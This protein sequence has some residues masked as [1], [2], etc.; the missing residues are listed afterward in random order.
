MKKRLTIKITQMAV[1][2]MIA[3]SVFSVVVP[4]VFANPGT[5][6]EMI[7][8]Q[9]HPAGSGPDGILGSTDDLAWTGTTTSGI[10]AA[11]FNF[12]DTIVIHGTTFYIGYQ[13]VDTNAD[14]VPDAP[15]IVVIDTDKNLANGV[16]VEQIID[17]DA[18]L[19]LL[20]PVP[21]TFTFVDVDGSTTYTAGDQVYASLGGAVAAL[22]IR[23]TPVG[24]Y[25]AGSQVVAGD[26]DI[27]T[28]YFGVIPPIVGFVDADV[29]GTYNAGD[30]VY[31]AQAGAVAANDIRLTPIGT[32]QAGRQVTAG[33]TDVGNAYSGF[34]PFA[35]LGAW[36]ADGSGTY[37]AGDPVYFAQGGAV[38][39]NDLRMSID[40]GV[41]GSQVGA[42]L[43]GLARI[44]DLNG[45]NGIGSGEVFAL[46]LIDDAA[47]A[48]FAINNDDDY[49]T[50]IELLQTDDPYDVTLQT[51]LY[52]AGTPAAQLIDGSGNE[53]T[54]DVYNVVWSGGIGTVTFFNKEA[55]YRGTWTLDIWDDSVGGITLVLEGVE[56]T[57]QVGIPVLPAESANIQLTLSP[58]PV[59]VE[60]TTTVT[61]R[62]TRDGVP[63]QA[64]VEA[65][66][67]DGAGNQVNSFTGQADS[68]GEVTFQI[69]YWRLR[70]L[71]VYAYYDHFD[72][73]ND[74]LDPTN[75]GH[76]M[77][78]TSIREL[79]GTYGDITI[80]DP[81][82][83]FDANGDTVNID[84]EY[85]FFGISST[86]LTEEDLAVTAD[87]TD[88]NLWMEQLFPNVVLTINNGDN[89]NDVD[90]PVIG[91]ANFPLVGGCGVYVDYSGSGIDH[92]VWAQDTLGNKYIIQVPT[93]GVTYTVW[94]WN[95]VGSIGVYD[96]L[97][98]IIFVGLANLN[99]PLP[100]DL[101]LDGD[102]DAVRFA[103]D[104]NSNGI[105]DNG[106]ILTVWDATSPLPVGHTTMTVYNGGVVAGFTGIEVS[107]NALSQA[108]IPV[109][110]LTT[111]DVTITTNLD[112]YLANTP[113][114]WT[115]DVAAGQPDNL[116]DYEGSI[117]IPVNA[118]AS[119][120]TLADVRIT[121][122]DFG[123]TV[124]QL[125]VYPSGDTSWFPV[126][127]DV[128][129]QPEGIDYTA[130][131][132]YDFNFYVKDTNGR[133][134]AFANGLNVWPLVTL[135]LTG[136]GIDIEVQWNDLDADS[137]YDPGEVTIISTDGLMDSDGSG[138]PPYTFGTGTA[139]PTIIGG[140][141]FDVYIDTDGPDNTANTIDDHQ[142]YMRLRPN[143]GGELNIR[144]E[145]SALQGDVN[146]PVG[147]LVIADVNGTEPGN[148]FYK[149]TTYDVN[150]RVLNEMGVVINNG[151]V[152]AW[153]D[154]DNNGDIYP[155]PNQG[156]PIPPVT[157][158]IFGDGIDND[159]DGQIDEFMEDEDG[160]GV[161]DVEAIDWFDARVLNTNN[162]SYS[163]QVTPQIVA[164]DRIPA[165]VG[166]GLH[167][168][169]VP[170]MITAY[171][172]QDVD[173]DGQLEQVEVVKA[174]EIIIPVNGQK[175][176]DITVVPPA[177]TAGVTEDELL[178]I[179]L[180]GNPVDITSGLIPPTALPTMLVQLDGTTFFN[181][182][183][184]LDTS[185]AVNGNVVDTG[186][187]FTELQ[188]GNHTY[189]V[190]TRD[191]EHWNEVIVPA[192]RPTVTYSIENS[193]LPGVSLHTMTGQM[194]R[195][196]TVELTAWDANG[197]MILGNAISNL[198]LPT[199]VDTRVTPFF[200]YLETGLMAVDDN[201][202]GVIDYTDLNG[203]G[204]PDAG[205]D[206]QWARG[207]IGAD[208]LYDL[209][210]YGTTGVDTDADG[211]WDI[212]VPDLDYP[213]FGPHT[214]TPGDSLNPDIGNGLSKF[215]IGPQGF[216]EIGFKV[217]KNVDTLAGLAS[218]VYTNEIVPVQM[219][220]LVLYDLNGVIVS[221]GSELPK[222]AQSTANYDM[223]LQQ[224]IFLRAELYPADVNDTALP[225][226][227]GFA[228]QPLSSIAE[229]GISGTTLL[230]DIGV[231]ET[232]LTITPT[233]LGNSN[234]R[235]TVNGILF[236]WS[237]IVEGIKVS[238]TPAE[239]VVSEM[240]SVALK[241]EKLS[242]SIE[243][244]GGVGI[245]ITGS[246]IDVTTVSDANGDITVSLT[247][248]STGTIQVVAT[249]AGFNPGYTT[250]DV[251]E[252]VGAE[253]ALLSAITP[254]SRIA[255]GGM[256]VTLFMSVINSG[257]A[258][259]TDVSI[260]QASSLPA[261]VSYQTWNGIALTGT[262]D[263]PVDIGPGATVHFV[264]T[265]NAT[266]AFATDS[267]TFD[268]SSTNGATAPIS[269]VNTL[270][271]SGSSVPYADVI[272]ISTSLDVSTAVNTATAFAVATT[273]VGGAN[274]T[275]VSLIVDIPSAITGLTVQVNETDPITGA[276]I[277]PASGMT[278]NM[279][280]QPTF[281]VFVT[282]TEA[283]S[284][285]PANNRITMRL[286]DGSGTVIGAQSVAISTT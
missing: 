84:D 236:A 30:P 12:E 26:T 37:N 284:F 24:T 234:I 241:T 67:T 285:D 286:V 201:H 205:D 68:N 144:V 166:D 249:K 192:E 40:A 28:A 120:L 215:W 151:K 136:G 56:P 203:N 103:I 35:A 186:R 232:K 212:R 156:P 32:Y 45:G 163:F 272:M 25:P 154:L 109:Y 127:V 80:F 216:G 172:Y 226:G 141:P 27:G 207:T 61:A 254:N 213:G 29:S 170:V 278:I 188:I 159:L 100:L 165:P 193:D 39:A 71:Q 125:Q 246:G 63:V 44:V 270:S 66:A 194:N 18:G 214:V 173:T 175:D 97:D 96:P 155:T 54:T 229:T 99:Q 126:D 167:E 164:L 250:I 73:A 36:D 160:D 118:L 53:F 268:V 59:K 235:Y 138:V 262:P 50:L 150:L 230:N 252:P 273:N 261:T 211:F 143:Q 145:S 240:T 124:N 206:D 239:I 8:M 3:I 133:H 202:N 200:T 114:V 95:D 209:G 16:R 279:G 62:V 225:D 123:A 161:P 190:D 132:E 14:A 183:D 237:D 244:L 64:H 189:R 171:Q 256:P 233:A 107:T 69:T 198:G 17:N 142:F 147:G 20:V 121:D 153:Q 57:K 92:V 266:A 208:E 260:A 181:N 101:D 231:A 22:D 75:P 83:G 78:L 85:D 251:V 280:D 179:F 218:D 9:F 105:I 33:D 184:D 7:A 221:P 204:I 117:S 93:D 79:D 104:V 88:L 110:P 31:I 70:E 168:T 81:N 34:A 263:T 271:I 162:G 169:P 195:L 98:T 245:S 131:A 283:I 269:G 51:D 277:G 23:I 176:L 191:Y 76:A 276:I 43:P 106:D 264:L 113:G 182:G 274:A 129:G 199:M 140:A 11:N 157:G 148:F 15:H 82:D 112:G 5:S 228:V 222:A 158:F 116:N 38:A 42:G 102:V 243:P 49:Y 223:T 258:T 146:Y 185:D 19:A 149:G 139:N 1:I 72:N 259:A 242:Y 77:F 134:Y 196:Y 197:N 65:I 119:G 178:T 60:Q 135:H 265:I 94:T 219:P 217:G 224:R 174:T 248:D 55:T 90:D 48:G 210:W 10:Q 89:P 122:I 13:I 255:Q 47:V 220:I 130:L 111:G 128:N 86:T 21:F 2:A 91:V 74:V 180:S 187:L 267:M 177:L 238:S 41:F 281:A 275:D 46:A 257:D 253:P 6:A 247:P 137:V 227:T 282:P 52:T 115:V 108:Q 87:R 58:T 152:I 4:S